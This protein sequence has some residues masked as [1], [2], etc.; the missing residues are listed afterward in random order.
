MDDP[1]NCFTDDEPTYTGPAPVAPDEPTHTEGVP[2]MT[3]MIAVAY[4]TQIEPHLTVEGYLTTDQAVT[5]TDDPML[6]DAQSGA[7]VTA[8]ACAEVVVTASETC[9]TTGAPS[10]G[11]VEHL[12]VE[13]A[14]RAG[15]HVRILPPLGSAVD[16]T[17]A[18][19]PAESVREPRFT[20]RGEYDLSTL[21][22]RLAAAHACLRVIAGIPTAYAH[23][24]PQACVDQMAQ[25]ARDFLRRLEGIP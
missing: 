24:G 8:S 16:F 1:T 2:M 13:G 10:L 6:V 5:R 7:P 19:T 14:L 15:Y 22:R 11:Q 9:E 18:P 20:V 23:A 21:A 4:A 25:A 17:R 12:L 3:D